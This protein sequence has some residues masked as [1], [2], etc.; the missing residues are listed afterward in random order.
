MSEIN[1]ESVLN[2]TFHKRL[3][4]GYEELKNSDLTI[5]SAQKFKSIYE[6]EE[7]TSIMDEASVIMKEPL[8]GLPFI[9]SLMLESKVPLY[10]YHPVSNFLSLYM[11][12]FE[13]KMSDDQK[14]IY[15]SFI[16]ELDGMMNKKKHLILL[17]ESSSSSEE[18]EIINSFYNEYVSYPS[19][20]IVDEFLSNESVSDSSKLTVAI[21]VL[22]ESD[23]GRL[24]SFLHLNGV[25]TESAE[26]D[27]EKYKKCV[28]FNVALSYILE[29]AYVYQSLKAIPNMELS[30]IIEDAYNE[31]YN[32]LINAIHSTS[33]LETPIFVSTERA[34]D[35]MFYDYENASVFEDDYN[36]MRLENALRSRAILESVHDVLFNEYLK[37]DVTDD[38]IVSNHLFESF[39]SEPMTYKDAITYISEKVLSLDETIDSL[40]N[41]N[42][43]DESF[44]EFTRGGEASSVIKK[45]AGNLREEK[46][47][48]NK[49]SSGNDDESEDDAEYTKRSKKEKESLTGKIQNK[50]IDADVKMQKSAGKMNQAMTNIKNAGKAVL[51]IPSNIVKSLKNGLDRWDKMDENKRK[52][53]ILEPGFRKEIFKFLRTAI[54][55][56]AI[57]QYKKYMVIVAWMCKHTLLHPFFKANKQRNARLRNELTAELDTE[58]AV[59][60]EKINDA[61]ANGD[62]KQ[63]YE[64]IRIKK[65]LE[66]ERQRV[67]TNSKY[68]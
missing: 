9:S 41:L 59:T 43:E 55:Y 25:M 40:Q 45:T 7:M 65:K 68:I 5:E 28:S 51:R 13:D 30:L 8:C 57:W 63:K 24:N 1:F 58:I 48:K 2:G 61:N 60:E 15:E 53:K 3:I 11:E 54:V 62:Q 42:N 35:Q 66:Y 29:D 26:S 16:H 21:D 18:R 67:S 6:N 4:R 37:S 12:E 52:E 64:L 10:Y 36:E 27:M 49:K 46:F 17:S 23:P 38:T 19:E 32:S 33:K 22:T 20:Y 50:A 31:N 39:S 47:S 44:F 56:G 34:V 14:A